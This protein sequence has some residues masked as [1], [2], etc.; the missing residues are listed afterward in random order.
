MVTLVR[1]LTPRD[2]NGKGH[3]P[4]NNVSGSLADW[5]VANALGDL[6]NPVAIVEL[7]MLPVEVLWHSYF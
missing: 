3:A 2:R 4:L 1:Y 6:L 7:S 5:T